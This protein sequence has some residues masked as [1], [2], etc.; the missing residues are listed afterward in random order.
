MVRVFETKRNDSTMTPR[1]STNVETLFFSILICDIITS[2]ENAILNFNKQFLFHP[3]V[4]NSENLQTPPEM[5]VIIGM[6]GSHLSGDVLKTLRPSIPVIIHSDYGLPALPESS[7]KKTLFVVSSYSGNTEET[8]DALTEAMNKGLHVVVIT[9][10][11][12]LLEIA[13]A[14]SLPH[15]ILPDDGIQPRSALGYSI[16]ALAEISGDS[17]LKNELNDLSKLE[18]ESFKKKGVRLAKLIKGKIPIVYSSVR[19]RSVAYNWKIKFNETGKVPAFYNVFPE[20]NHNEMTG[21]D[22]LDSNSF[23]SEKFIW[24][25]IQGGEEH[26]QNQKRIKV[27]SELLEERELETILIKLQGSSVSEEVFSSLL[28]ADW[29]SLQSANFYGV[30]AE[31]VPMIEEFKKRIQ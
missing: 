28:I 30:E 22:V 7:M 26:P 18:P 24:L 1:V 4:I 10:G 15:I 12:K 20:L 27:T 31:E 9:T 3:E 23:L 29:A 5:L 21:F 17:S 16:K 14:N 8:V 6:G 13:Q 2:M 25:F 19:Y 11:G